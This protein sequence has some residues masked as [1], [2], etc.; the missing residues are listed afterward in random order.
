MRRVVTTL[1]LLLVVI[2]AGL[3][4]LVVLVNPNEFKQN[5]IEQVANESG[6]KLTVS[7]QLRW[8]VW[9]KLSILGAAITL[10]A[11]DAKLP[12]LIANDVRFDVALLPLLSHHLSI[13][14]VVMR[15]AI[16]QLVPDS[17]ASKEGG[18]AIASNLAATHNNLPLIRNFYLQQLALIDSLV[19]WQD[20]RGNQV[21]FRQ[22]NLI[23]NQTAPQQ[24]SFSFSSQINRNQQ[25]LNLSLQGNFDARRYLG[26]VA[27]QVDEGAYNYA[28]FAL[29]AAKVAGSLVFNGLFSPNDLD[30]KVNEIQMTANGNQFQGTLN[31]KLA[32]APIISANLHSTRLNMNA[33]FAPTEEANST[34]SQV[35]SKGNQEG[36]SQFN[37]P[38][39]AKTKINLDLVADEVSWNSLTAKQ[40]RLQSQLADEQFSLKSLSG[41]IAQG[42]F[43]VTGN[44]NFQSVPLAI[45]LAPK[46][47]NFPLNQLLKFINLPEAFSGQLDLSGNLTSRGDGREMLLRN[48][49]GLLDIKLNAFDAKRV[50]L[51]TIVANA[52]QRNSDL[53]QSSKQP[54]EVPQL[55]GTLQLTPGQVKIE[56]LA[57]ADENMQLRC[58][59]GV[60][61]TNRKLDVLLGILMKHWQGDKQLVNLLSTQTVPLRLYGAW[62]D[63]HYQMPINE[64]LKT[65]LQKDFKKRIDQWLQKNT[66]EISNLKTQ[67]TH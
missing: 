59:G 40:F 39:L 5:L 42:K 51:T 30:F 43:A 11:P 58:Q 65:D 21:N 28:G 20:P 32:A 17:L 16:L 10:Q 33:F 12:L 18:Q 37:D 55:I 22:T 48:W 54:A 52:V 7:G 46:L 38:W 34:I 27:L 66:A 56:H 9:P 25:Q 67:Y 13:N 45:N 41:S 62:D 64:I 44:I 15:N 60:D 31:G 47:K 26:A 8:H 3:A 29:P 23:I 35:E 49:Q 63:L 4:T 6:Y 19:V 57:G 1:V 53:V 61:L 36:M 24:G 2:V 14:Q 50:N